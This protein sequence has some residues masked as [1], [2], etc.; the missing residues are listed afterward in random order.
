MN[1][2]MPPEAFK[3]QS[4]H[5]AKQNTKINGI[6]FPKWSENALQKATQC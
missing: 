1:P 2:K 4:K 3:N 5:E 6:E